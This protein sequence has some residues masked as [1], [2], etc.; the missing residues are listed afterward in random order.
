MDLL[1]PGWLKVVG[2]GFI[3]G[4]TLIAIGRWVRRR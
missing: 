4:L 3:L 1:L 2:A